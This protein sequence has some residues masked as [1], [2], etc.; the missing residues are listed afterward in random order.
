MKH[1]DFKMFIALLA[2]SMMFFLSFTPATAGTIERI[3][4]AMDGA[5]GD[6]HSM[7]PQISGD[8]RYVA[9]LSDATNLA[10]GDAVDRYNIHIH[11]RQ[12]GETVRVGDGIYA[13]GNSGSTYGSMSMSANGGRLAFMVKGLDSLAIHDINTNETTIYDLSLDGL[14]VVYK[15]EL[16]DDGNRIAFKSS[17]N[18][19]NSAW[20]QDCVDQAKY[21]LIVLDMDA[22]EL[23][24]VPFKG[25]TDILYFID[26]SLNG[27]GS[28]IALHAYKRD[29]THK[30]IRSEKDIYTYDFLTDKLD[31]ITDTKST[32]HAIDKDKHIMRVFL[33]SLSADGER[34][35]YA[36]EHGFSR[37]NF[38]GDR[39]VVIDSI[40][41]GKGH[42]ITLENADRPIMSADGNSVLHH[43]LIPGTNRTGLFVYDLLS[44]TD[45]LV[46]DSANRGADISADGRYVVFSSYV[47]DLVPGDTN[48][49]TDI[50]IYDRG[51]R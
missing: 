34:L 10:S 23:S 49:L 12:T 8:G 50:F 2:V 13:S 9:Y 25:K 31:A 48:M 6:G 5:E 39:S 40:G 41:K 17:I 16:S 43:G 14:S 32:M 18:E 44:G 26:Y 15:L 47:T 51:P 21:Q 27:D 30:R 3:S 7:A 1:I 33:P 42:E 45:E 36:S 28:K 4:I 11:D 29:L 38:I 22:E 24:C 37:S 35:A 46:A 19:Q 20:T